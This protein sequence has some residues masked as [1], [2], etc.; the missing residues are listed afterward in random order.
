MTM[1]AQNVTL[2]SS[3]NKD[4]LFERFARELPPETE[5]LAREFKAF[6]FGRK[7][8]TPLQLLHVVFLYCSLDKSLR[9]TA[10]NFTLLYE[11]I[12]DSSIHERLRACQPW[13][14]AVLRQ[15][16]PTLDENTPEDLHWWICDGSKIAALASKGVEYRLHAAI[17]LRTLEIE[18]IGQPVGR[19]LVAGKVSLCPC[20]RQKS[21][22]T[23]ARR[24]PCHE[25][26][27][28][29]HILETLE[30]RPRTGSDR[31]SRRGMLERRAH[32]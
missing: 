22:E 18:Q 21:E 3:E 32:A 20:S 17:N 7:S 8:K 27:P 4:Q 12:T 30:D 24:K 14:K 15:M 13:L 19:G 6:T 10:A 5:A 16:L 31:H 11:K 28:K 9:E 2:N 26:K 23:Y 25:T 29:H 1:P